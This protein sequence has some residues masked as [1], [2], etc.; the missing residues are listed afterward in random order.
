METTRSEMSAGEMEK[1]GIWGHSQ[2]L[3]L[4]WKQGEASGKINA[5][6]IFYASS[7]NLLF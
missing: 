1:G 3:E 4:L 5:L 6:W 2:A 7:L